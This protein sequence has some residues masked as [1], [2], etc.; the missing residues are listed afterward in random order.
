[1][2]TLTQ[3]E[4]FVEGAG[5]IKGALRLITRPVTAA[6]RRLSPKQ[7]VIDCGYKILSR[8][9]TARYS[10]RSSGKLSHE[11]V[12]QATRDVVPAYEGR[13]PLRDKGSFSVKPPHRW[14]PGE[15]RGGFQ[16]FT[17]HLEN[18]LLKDQTASIVQ[19][20]DWEHRDQAQHPEVTF[21]PLCETDSATITVSLP[22]GVQISEPEFQILTHPS[23][24]TFVERKS[25]TVGDNILTYPIDRL[26]MNLYYR[27]T[28]KWL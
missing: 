28:W 8:K 16:L 6:W 18:P 15:K 2:W 17:I 19:E 21:I 13:Y 7:K 9:I 24:H 20:L 14:I 25:I 23:A 26:E 5:A 3:V 4:E 1:M 11:I 22:D 27:V 12:M 10:T